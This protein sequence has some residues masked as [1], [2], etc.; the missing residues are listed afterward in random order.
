MATRVKI[1]SIILLLE[2][3]TL[4]CLQIFLS[5]VKSCS[6]VPVVLSDLAVTLTV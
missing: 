3:S 1:T 6:D 4:D 5:G 2:L